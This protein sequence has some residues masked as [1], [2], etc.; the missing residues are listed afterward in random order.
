[1]ENLYQ[2]PN[3][4]PLQQNQ[5]NTP[6][7][8]PKKTNSVLKIVAG[9]IILLIAGGGYL[10]YENQK[11]KDFLSEFDNF[12]EQEILKGIE[13]QVDDEEAKEIL[14]E[15]RQRL[16]ENPDLTVEKLLEEER[17]KTRDAS[18]LT[19]VKQI[20]I[21][22]GLYFD[23]YKKYP[24]TLDALLEDGDFG[25]PYL[26]S[27]PTNPTPGGIDYEYKPT[28]NGGSYEIKYAREL[29]NGEDSS[30]IYI[31][32]PNGLNKSQNWEPVKLRYPEYTGEDLSKASLRDEKRVN[33]SKWIKV[34]LEN[35]YNYFFKYPDNL[36]ILEGEMWKVPTNPTPGGIDYKYQ[37]VNGGNDYILEYSLEVGF[38]TQ[39][40][41]NSYLYKKGLHTLS[42]DSLDYI[43]EN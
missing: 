37:A 8:E 4:E 27:I 30:E 41:F 13:N 32:T 28:N 7:P 39:D 2:N 5:S 16:E 29:N 1:M 23:D 40:Q 31:A 15:I 9:V 36:F 25:T 3:Q 35:Y 22:L 34:S 24:D 17:Q 33:D 6:E 42:K 12:I 43:I 21:A 26:F 19:D 11:D 38:S 14:E 20:Q 10:Y 18:R